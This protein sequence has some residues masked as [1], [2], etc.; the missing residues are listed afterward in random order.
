MAPAQKAVKK[1]AKVGE[2]TAVFLTSE[3]GLLGWKQGEY[4][5]AEVIDEKGEKKIILKKVSL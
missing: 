3:I 5:S 4:V 2:G 1:L